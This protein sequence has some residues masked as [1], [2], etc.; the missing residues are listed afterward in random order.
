[1]Y[2]VDLANR[3]DMEYPHGSPVRVAARRRQP[4]IGLI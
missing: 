3:S 1:L 4:D 2:W